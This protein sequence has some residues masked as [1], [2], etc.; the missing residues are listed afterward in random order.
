MDITQTVLIC[1]QTDEL[2]GCWHL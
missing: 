2:M 1:P